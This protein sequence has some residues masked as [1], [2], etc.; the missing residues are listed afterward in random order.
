MPRTAL[1][2][3]GVAGDESMRRERRLAQSGYD[4]WVKMG[5]KV[6]SERRYRVVVAGG[7]NDTAR[8]AFNGWRIESV[9]G[10]TA[11]LGDMDQAALHG[12]LERILWLCL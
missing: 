12:G 2:T 6:L 9:D 1:G 11:L 8:E 10:D 7:L 5:H 3:S 4:L